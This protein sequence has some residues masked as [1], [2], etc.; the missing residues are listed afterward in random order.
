MAE[1]LPRVLGLAELLALKEPLREKPAPLIYF[2]D[3]EFA[4]LL[5]GVEELERAPRVTFGRPTFVPT[6][7]GVV[8]SSCSSPPGQVCVGQTIP[9]GPDHPGG[10]FFD[11]RCKVIDEPTPIPLITCRVLLDEK[12]F[13]C[14]GDCGATG[15]T[16]RLGYWRDPKT[17][18]VTLDCRCRPELHT[19]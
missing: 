11:C 7:S 16:C 4:R 18:I 3:R 8:Q 13:R 15:R 6:G 19:L 10:I 1:R 14:V 9:S 5:K 2:T 12:G 17:G